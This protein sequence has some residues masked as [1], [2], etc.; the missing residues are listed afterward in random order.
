LLVKF[1]QLAT[2]GICPDA[3]LSSPTLA[4]LSRGGPI[5]RRTVALVEVAVVNG[6]VAL[7]RPV[8][9]VSPLLH[10]LPRHP[11]AT[12]NRRGV[13]GSRRFGV[14]MRPFSVGPLQRRPLSVGRGGV[15][16]RV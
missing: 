3:C 4:C 11:L 2:W 1:D 13:W 6:S 15:R 14:A 10:T 7:V 9:R 12:P 5:R 8:R 16:D